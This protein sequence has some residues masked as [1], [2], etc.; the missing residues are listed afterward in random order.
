MSWSAFRVG[1]VVD[2]VVA[3]CAN[4]EGGAWQNGVLACRRVIFSDSASGAR[5]APYRKLSEAEVVRRHCLELDAGS[6]GSWRTIIVMGGSRDH[7]S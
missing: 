6:F 1:D 2:D 3:A 4:V 5:I 7:T